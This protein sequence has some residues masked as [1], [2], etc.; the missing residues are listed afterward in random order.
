MTRIAIMCKITQDPTELP[1]YILLI[2]FLQS[3]D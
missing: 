2:E 3:H 1:S